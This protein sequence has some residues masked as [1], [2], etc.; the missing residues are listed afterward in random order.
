ML[1]TLGL[2]HLNPVDQNI[3]TELTNLLNLAILPK[4]S[5]HL[6]LR[7]VDLSDMGRE[8]IKVFPDV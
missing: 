7:S 8:G 5:D 4:V 2:K 6:E 1:H 3:I